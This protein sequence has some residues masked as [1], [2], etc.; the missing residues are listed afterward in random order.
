MKILIV[1]DEQFIHDALGQFF[2][3]KNDE[4]KGAKDIKT[5]QEEIETFKP[6]LVLLDVKL[7]KESGLDVLKYIKERHKDIKVILVTGFNDTAMQEKANT[8]GADGIFFKPISIPNLNKLI[9]E[10]MSK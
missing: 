1:D 8:L 10:V 4:V 3:L 9:K 7:D 5:A 2:Q 6:Q